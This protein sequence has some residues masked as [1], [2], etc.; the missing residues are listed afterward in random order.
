MTVN[1]SRVRVAAVQYPLRPVAGF[2]DFAQQL[3]HAV[4]VAA[5]YGCD[6]VL[7]PELFTLQLLSAE[8]EKLPGTEAVERLTHHTPALR[9]LFVELAQRHRINLVGGTHITRLADGQVRNVCHVA[10]RDGSLH[11]RHK[12]HA[13]PSEARYW[14]VSGGGVADAL[15]IDT[16]RGRIGIMICYDSEFPELAR[17]LTDA[18]A[19]LFFVPYCTD[20]R[21]GYLRVRYCCQAR[22]VENQT[23]LVLAGTVGNLPGVGNFDIQ[24]AQNAVLTPC[25]LPFARDGIAA[26]ATPNVDQILIA[27]LDL[28]ALA[29][30]REHGTVRNL[31][32]RRTDLYRV[33]W[34]AD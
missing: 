29:T 9:E 14:G 27:D 32:D 20:D 17:R 21:H 26:E 25:D 2:A 5:D 33:D 11:E 34:R 6:F 30:A 16:D 8:V 7:F 3:E 19:G 12:L 23:M 15:P 24:Y 22:A 28:S 4:F 10:L 31:A 13:T 18:G 1:A